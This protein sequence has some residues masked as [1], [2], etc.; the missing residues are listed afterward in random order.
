[1]VPVPQDTEQLDQ[2]LQGSDAGRGG[3]PVDETQLNGLPIF[4]DG[5]RMVS[6]VSRQLLSKNDKADGGDMGLSLCLCEK[7]ETWRRSG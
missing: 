6:R 4:F 3:G 5:K 7:G 1:M 2:L